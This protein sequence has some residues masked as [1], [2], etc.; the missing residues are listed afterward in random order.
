MQ[1]EGWRNGQPHQRKGCAKS[2]SETEETQEEE[3]RSSESEESE[4]RQNKEEEEEAAVTTA[5]RIV[6][7]NTDECWHAMTRKPPLDHVFK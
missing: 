6:I 5:R 3:E 7:F 4:E 2:R 1:R